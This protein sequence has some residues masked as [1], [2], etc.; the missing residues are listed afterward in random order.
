MSQLFL[1]HTCTPVLFI[2]HDQPYSLN[3]FYYYFFLSCS[4]Y[5]FVM[6][7]DFFYLN[8]GIVSISSE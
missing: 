5:Y 6:F 1:I 8:L 7:M 3:R 4:I 2:F